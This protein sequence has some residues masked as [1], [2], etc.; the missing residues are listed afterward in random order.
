MAKIGA[1]ICSCL[2]PP[3][4]VQLHEQVVQKF[5][6]AEVGLQA[7]FSPQLFC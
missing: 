6:N 4:T 2:G 7:G 5:T 1:A 3:I